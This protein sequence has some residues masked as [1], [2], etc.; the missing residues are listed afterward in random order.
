VSGRGFRAL[1]LAVL[2][3]GCALLPDAPHDTV[4]RG[5]R[6]ALEAF[7]LLGRIAVLRGNDRVSAGIAWRHDGGS[8]EIVLSGPLG[9]GIARLSAGPAGATLE[10]AERRR[11]EAADV[12]AL[13]ERLFGAPLPVSGMARW[14]VGRAAKGSPTR[15]DDMRRPAVLVEDGWTIEFEQFETALPDALPVRL[16]AQRD[17]IE[18]RLI[19]DSWESFP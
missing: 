3:P 8:D 6:E 14:V 10:T 2:L 11:Q 18:V 12:D 7:R 17:G 16:R 4:I 1:A 19:I 15:L 5:P 9:Q 13:A